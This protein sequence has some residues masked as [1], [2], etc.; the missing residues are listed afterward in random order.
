VTPPPGPLRVAVST[1]SPVV[2]AGVDPDHADAAPRTGESLV[3]AGHR[4]VEADPPY[5][6]RTALASLGRWFAGAELDARLLRDRS[7]LEPRLRTQAALGRAV[8]RAGSP[9]E[10]GRQH[11][12]Q[13]AEQLEQLRP[14]PR[15]APT[16]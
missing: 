10:R 12:R 4:V 11:W 6:I 9:R 1:R 8:L 2:G 13:V 7:V 5:P 3:G 15:L 14:W 16:R